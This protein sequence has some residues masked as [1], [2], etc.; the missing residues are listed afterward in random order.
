MDKL[1][2]LYSSIFTLPLRSL[3]AHVILFVEPNCQVSPPFGLVTTIIG[4][5]ASAKLALLSSYVSESDTNE[6]L[7]L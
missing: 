1:P 2:P 6:T 4:T 7:T 5:T 3:L